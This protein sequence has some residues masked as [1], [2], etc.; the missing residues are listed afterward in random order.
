[1]KINLVNIIT[2][3]VLLGLPAGYIFYSAIF[4]PSAIGIWVG[5]LISFLGCA[6]IFYEQYFG[7]GNYIYGKNKKKRA[8]TSAVIIVL[9]FSGLYFFVLG[10]YGVSFGI[11]LISGEKAIEKNKLVL[12]GKTGGRRL[13][14]DY[15]A[16]I[17][18]TGHNDIRF[19]ISQG[20]HAHLHAKK[21]G[22]DIAVMAEV[23]YRRSAFGT[24][25]LGIEK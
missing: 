1:M 20:E 17:L 14:C 16:A 15:S 3:L 2:S 10:A 23:A 7:G 8:K 25:I 13:R 12:L 9:I 19:C 4:F 24:Q 6:L 5:V 18:K 22:G 11:N 21:E